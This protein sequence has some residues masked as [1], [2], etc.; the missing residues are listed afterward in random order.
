MGYRDQEMQWTGELEEFMSVTM[1]LSKGQLKALDGLLPM[2]QEI[3]SSCME[4]CIRI[5]AYGQAAKLASEYPELFEV[6]ISE[7]NVQEES[8]PACT[9]RTDPVWKRINN[10]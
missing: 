9:L 2:T 4:K 6:Y 10:I 3:F 7:E 1:Q 5:G 8:V